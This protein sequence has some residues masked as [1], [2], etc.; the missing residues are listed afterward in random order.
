MAKISTK[1]AMII[2]SIVIVLVL[3]LV[4]RG[5]L[6]S[7]GFAD[8]A[9]TF[10]LYYADWCPHC[11]TV[12]PV[13]ADWSKKGSV[14]INGQQ[15]KTTMV[16]ESSNTDKSAPVKGYPTMLL[17]KSD[18]SYVEFSGDRSPSGWESW[19]SQNI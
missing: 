14:T 19:L 17:K 15:V 4:F 3:L 13:F 7:E 8:G 18:G 11:K 12:K 1:Y 9:N 6:S 2:G 16:E 5:R 10:T